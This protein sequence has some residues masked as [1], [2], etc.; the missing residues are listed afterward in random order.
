[1][2]QPVALSL[3]FIWVS[4]GSIAFSVGVYMLLVGINNI[5]YPS[6]NLSFVQHVL[7]MDGLRPWVPET[8]AEARAVTSPYFHWLAFW[9]IVGI[10]VVIGIMCLAAGLIMLLAK[11]HDHFYTGKMCYLAGGTLCLLFWFN[12]FFIIGSEWF[13]MW[14][15]ESASAQM[16]SLVIA[17]FVLLSMVFI[18]QSNDLE[19]NTSHHG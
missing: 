14:A 11:S 6:V 17:L 8:I 2:S 12:G 1:M 7:A 9:L 13:F 4:K 15:S 3:R 5:L 18:G 19:S 10:E 16:K